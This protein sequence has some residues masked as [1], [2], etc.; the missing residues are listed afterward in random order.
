M[1]RSLTSLDY[2]FMITMATFA[3]L[4]MTW[5]LYLNS[6][7][8][9]KVSKKVYCKNCLYYV[10]CNSPLNNLLYEECHSPENTISTISIIDNYYEHNECTH[11]IYLKKPMELNLINNCRFYENALWIKNL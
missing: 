5:V 6:N 10:C 8:N 2:L 11:A 3:I 4:V 7:E 1:I 9:K